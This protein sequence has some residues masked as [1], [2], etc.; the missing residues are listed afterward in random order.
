[1]C[2]IWM[3]KSEPTWLAL[4]VVLDASLCDIISIKE[5]YIS[6]EYKYF[7]NQLS[8]DVHDAKWS[9]IGEQTY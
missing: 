2:I 3:I 9:A 7:L 6:I 5:F 4:L 8:I 1:M